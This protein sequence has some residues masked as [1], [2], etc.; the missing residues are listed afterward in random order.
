MR[1]GGRGRQNMAVKKILEEIELNWKVNER[2]NKHEIIYY[3][4][5]FLRNNKSEML[6]VGVEINKSTSIKW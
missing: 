2:E 5:L 1:E 4:L 3:L 6:W